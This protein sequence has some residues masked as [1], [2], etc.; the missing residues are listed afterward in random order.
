MYYVILTTINITTISK[1]KTKISMKLSH[2]KKIFNK[3]IINHKK[4][5]LLLY[6]KKKH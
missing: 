1:L 5:L 3:K 2:F 4:L 6:L